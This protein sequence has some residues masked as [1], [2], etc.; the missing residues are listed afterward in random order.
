MAYYM[1]W[2]IADRFGTI[3]ERVTPIVEGCGVVSSHRRGRCE[4]LLFL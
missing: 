1:A 3:D 4:L 2:M